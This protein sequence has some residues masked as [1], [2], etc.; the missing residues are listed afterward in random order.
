MNRKLSKESMMLESKDNIINWY[1]K[2]RPI[3]DIA[4]AFGV[5]E[6]TMEEF[7]ANGIEQDFNEID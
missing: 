6:T 1:W 4:T 7:I 3:K 5:S 2:G